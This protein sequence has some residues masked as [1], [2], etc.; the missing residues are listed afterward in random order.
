MRENEKNNSLA[1]AIHHLSVS[2]DDKPILKDINLNVEVGSVHVLMGPNGSGKTSL[3][4]TL[5]GHPRYKV[6]KGSISLNGQHI[7]KLLADKRARMGLFLSFQHPYEVP[8]VTVFNFLKEAYQA[9]AQKVV[10]VKE[11]KTV[12]VPFMERLSLD[13]S[14]MY[15][16][17]NDGF[18]GG[19]KKCL[20][21]LQL[22]V[23][24][25]DVVILDEID[26]GLDVDALKTVGKALSYARQ[27][28]PELSMVVITHYQKILNYIKPDC[29]H[30]ISAGS[31]IASGDGSLAGL[32]ERKGYDAFQQIAR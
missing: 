15:R 7:D 27:Q 1:L 17:V 5:A 23:L 4:Y 30:I 29:V 10:S 19:E 18:S 8:G 9:V 20:E 25:P 14:Y 16:N 3:A 32:V 13:Q 2:V 26:S 21:M 28:N 24:N 11:F 22:L 31:L 6:I 12:V